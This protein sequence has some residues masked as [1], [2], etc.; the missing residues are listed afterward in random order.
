MTCIKQS[1]SR[2]FKDIN[3]LVT[4]DEIQV[5]KQCI[6]CAYILT[7][8]ILILWLVPM[9]DASVMFKEAQRDRQT[10]WFC[11]YTERWQW[12]A[13]DQHIKVCAPAWLCLCVC[14]CVPTDRLRNQP[15]KS[16]VQTQPLRHP[17]TLWPL[18]N[19]RPHLSLLNAVWYC[20]QAVKKPGR[21]AVFLVFVCPDGRKVQVKWLKNRTDNN[22]LELTESQ[23]KLHKASTTC[24][25]FQIN[26]ARERP[27]FLGRYGN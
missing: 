16:L 9:L 10:I 18:L 2:C 7:T 1:G 15:V 14:V 17:P 13:L 27:K 5:L 12:R 25:S 20:W 11:E 23:P 4:E 24:T 19:V 22:L 3:L 21:A 26:V 8:Y 6:M